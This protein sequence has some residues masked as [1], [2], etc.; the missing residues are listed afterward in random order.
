MGIHKEIWL[1]EIVRKFTHEGTFLE[2]VQDYSRYAENDVIH[3]VDAGAKPEVLI[4]NNTYPIP[5]QELPDGD[6]TISLD[7]FQTKATS[8]TD[9]ELH[10]ISYK[11]I[12]HVTTGHRESLQ[13][14]TADKA[15]HALAPL[16][17]T[18]DT[19]ILKTTGDL[20]E[21]QRM[22]I[23]KDLIRLKKACDDLKIP[24]RSRNIILS[25][26]HENDLLQVDEKFEKQFV[27]RA[28]G[29]VLN[30]MGFNFYTFINTPKYAIDATTKAAAKVAFGAALAGTE[31][32][33]SAFFYGPNTFKAIG[34]LKRYFAEAE[35]D[36]IYQR[37]LINYRQMFIALPKVLRGMAAVVSNNE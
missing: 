25:T 20:V 4:N 10:A 18:A 30:Y 13:E 26:R 34:S 14:S 35:K 19:P 31:V 29:K 24:A 11:K 6:I 1:G 12:E 3:L 21:G 32:D 15:A 33:A 5:I 28:E 7:K 16:Q 27:N 36:P 2:A 8:I 17:N 37:N 22:M 23:H 9:D